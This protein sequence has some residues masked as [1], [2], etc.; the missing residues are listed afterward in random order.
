MKSKAKMDN[1]PGFGEGAVRH[2]VSKSFAIGADGVAFSIPVPIGHVVKVVS[3]I[4][5][6][7]AVADEIGIYKDTVYAKN[8]AGTTSLVGATLADV[9]EEDATW[10]LVPTAND[11]TDAI[12]F[13][14]TVDAT[15][16]STMTGYYYVTS[17]SFL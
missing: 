3:E 6:Y 13:T 8:L 14:A 10:A 5:L 12:D 15:N 7:D 9:V 11:T 4:M 17:T 1:F 16:A 2:S